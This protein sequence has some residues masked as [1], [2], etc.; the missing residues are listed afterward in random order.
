MN[1]RQRNLENKLAAL[2][3][4][5]SWFSTAI[6]GAGLAMAALGMPGMP[7]VNAGIALFIALPVVRV[8]FMLGFFLSARD[9][10]FSG[11]CVFILS[12]I[13]LAS[14]IG[15]HSAAALEK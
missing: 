12:V 13:V 15:L 4:Y 9:F 3:H 7:V 1:E 11:I 6:I 8:V 10:R 5:G 14:A 2:L